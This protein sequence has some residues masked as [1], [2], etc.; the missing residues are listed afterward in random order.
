MTGDKK[1][2][3]LWRDSAANQEADNAA[4]G[5]T[6]PPETALAPEA[7]AP[8]ERDWLDMS[9]LTD[10][11]DGLREADETSV[12]SAWRDRIAPALLVLLGIGWTG[13]ALAVATGNFARGPALAD[14]PALVATIAMPLT[15][16]AVLWMALLRS[17]RSEQARFA[18]VAAALREENMALNQ[19]MH[20]LGLH[21]ADA[22]K[23]LGEQAKLVQQLGLDTVMRLNE[24]SDK[25]ASNASV[26]ANAH[27]QLARSGDVA[28]QR[29]DGLLAGLPRIDDV[30]QRLA[31][32][33]REAGLV[34][35]QQ[36]ASLEAKLAALGEEAAKAA[37]AGEASTASMLEA[38]VALQ[39][40]AKETEAGLLAASTEVGSAHDAALARMTSVGAAARDD[41]AAT[42]AA[43]TGQMDESWRLFRDGVDQAAGQMDA[44]LAAARDAGDAMG[45]QLSAHADASDALASRIT[46]HVADVAQQLELL[47]VSVSASTGVI[48]RAIGDTKTQLG[49]FLQEVESGNASAHQ[50]ISHAESLLLALDAVTRE[51]DETLPHAL[52]RM[53]SHGKAT[54]TAL[55]QLRP[56]LEASELVA[57]STMSHVN[58][59]QATLKSNEDQM[60]SHATSQQALVDRINGSLADAEAA[61]AKL[62]DGADE[63]AEQ[64]GARMIATLSEVRATADSAAEEAR[65]TLEKLVSGAREAMQATATEAIDAAFKNEI[66]AQLTAIEE[67]SARAVAAANGAADR[68]MRQLIT[69]MDTS[70]SVE[71]RVAEAE[72]AIAASGRDSLAKQVGLLTEALKSTAIDVTKILSSEV[73]DTAWDAYLKGDRGVFA[74]RAV[75]LIESGEAK[76]ILRLYQNDDGFHASVNQF[77]H[78]FEAMLRLLIGARDGSA[79]SVTLLSS[80]IGKLY[81]AL[82]QAI[83]RLRN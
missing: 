8:I 59:V 16:L 3:G 76:E 50:L 36:G 75:K 51:L 14:W 34:A 19:S 28:L 18:R 65:Q 80:D 47:D 39:E 83:D 31:V 79:I 37:Q 77:I 56:M 22:Q 44:K 72:Q 69:I 10:A 68:L 61:L 27:D 6:A 70:A 21:L 5:E 33:F 45:A 74:R 15:L 20:S 12:P 42:V 71:Q 41:M 23:Q 73:S 60:A 53:T 62:R 32:N 11:D 81:V 46:S 78:D 7:E 48:G 66:M 64:G 67:A 38:I 17:S 25:L 13:F 55:S 26:I 24:S 40:Q 82:A 9:S 43:L 4:A 63:F 2:V 57:Q 49:A 1:I 29:M 30:A 52:D 58:A 35:H 54:Q